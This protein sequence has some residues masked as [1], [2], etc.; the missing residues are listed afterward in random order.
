[1]NLG[2]LR[3]NVSSRAPKL[4]GG[5]AIVISIPNSGRTWIRTFLAAYFC[6]RYDHPF[7]LDP[8]QYNDRRIPR[9]IY[10]HDLY[11]HHTKTRWWERVRSKFLVPRGEI[12]RANLLL[13]ARDPRDAFV[14]HYVELTRRTLETA[15]E[16]KRQSVSKMMRDSLFGIDLM[17]QT[18]N[19]WINEFGDRANCT[20]IRYEDLRT[21]PAEQFR[22]VLAGVGEREPIESH[23]KTALEFSQFGNMKKME[24]SRAY[25]PK[26]LQPADVSD[27]ESYK[28]RRGKVGG[29]ADYL[30]SD[31]AEYARKAVAKLDP[32][33]G[34]R[35]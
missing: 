6:A 9:V 29:Y 22:R 1:M 33:F 24:A 7:L 4:S 34:Y 10:T 8:D 14:S 20:L 26:L 18:M 13:L 15:E 27:P 3:W 16:L 12:K 19:N 17:I 30:G 32:R 2:Q 31:D 5:D 28:V 11:E 21:A 25:D 35:A 23:F